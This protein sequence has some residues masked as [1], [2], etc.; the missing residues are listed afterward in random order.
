MKRKIAALTAQVYDLIVI[1]GGI[2][3]VYAAWDAALR[4]L[5]V[6]LVEQGDFGHATSANHFKL[7]HGGIRYL[8]HGDLRRVR[9]SSRERSTLLRVAPHLVQPLPFVFPTYGHGLQGKEAMAAGL[10]LY[11]LLTLDRNQGIRDPKRQIGAGYTLSRQRCL[12]LF[13]AL[14]PQG[15]TGAAVFQESQ[16]YNPT[17]LTLAC[18]RA[19]VNAGVVAANYVQATGFLQKANQ[20]IGIQA[21]DRFSQEGLAIRGRVVINAAGPWAD[22]LLQKAIGHGLHTKPSF[23]RDALFVVKRPLVSEEYALALPARTKDA[24]ALISR[25]HRHLFLVPWRGH[26]L[27][28]VWHRLHQGG[29]DDYKITEQDLQG[30]IAEVNAAYPALQLTLDDVAMCNA[31]LILF[32]AEGQ[33]QSKHSFGKR[34]LVID[35]AQTHQ[36]EGLLTLI[37]VRYTTARGV[38]EQAIDRVLAKLGQ[39]PRRSQTAVTPVYGGAIECFN[40]YLQQ[41]IHQ[42]PPTLSPAVMPALVHNYGSAHQEILAY[43]DENPCWLQRLGDSNVL[44]AEVIHAVRTEMAQ[45]LSDVVFRRTDLGTGGHPGAAALHECATLLAAELAWDARRIHEERQ[46]VER[47]FPRF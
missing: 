8:Q 37:G 29:P 41:A 36:I 24:D 39:T 34:S 20:V 45:T 42:C 13:P 30:F 6:A 19:A 26:T 32:G 31:G 12:A 15:L 40:E 2:F 33:E 28:G 17:R 44:K 5:T 16:M 3:G 22:D 1:G 14:A 4:G 27:V 7:V 25:G 9:E 18:L 43:G 23:S 46:Q 38:A 11:D 47:L 10:L 35:H 21:Q